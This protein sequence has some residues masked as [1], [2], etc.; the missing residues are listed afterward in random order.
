MEEKDTLYI[1][2]GLKDKNELW[3]GFGK[4]EAFKALIFITIAS[5]IDILLYFLKQNIAISVVF[6]LVAIGGSLMMLTKDTT[7]I[8]VV[9][10]I[11]YMIRFSKSQKY[12]SYIYLDEWR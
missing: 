6:I 2:L 1:P 8:S 12:Y 11:G 5:I 3:D 4:E 10:Q 9:D 7:N